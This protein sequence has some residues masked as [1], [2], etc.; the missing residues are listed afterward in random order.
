MSGGVDSSIAAHLLKNAGYSLVGLTM[1]IWDNRIPLPD[2]GFSG[3]FGPGEARDIAAAQ[4]LAKRLDIPHH[5]VPLANEYAD[6]ILS[7]FRQE[8]TAGRTP[9]P[10]VRCN[11][12]MKF[13]LLLQR[14]RSMGITF[15]HF[16]TGHYARVEHDP[17]SGRHLLYRAVDHRKDQSYFL[18]RLDQPKLANVMFPLGN[19]TKDAV[20]LLARDIGWSDVADKDE[21]QNFIESDNYGVLFNK[22]E[23][24]PGPIVDMSGNILGQHKGIIHYTIGQRRG[25]GLSG[26]KDPLFVVRLEACANTVVVGS[27]HELFATR[28]QATHVNWISC[29]APPTTPVRVQAKIRQQHQEAPA[30]LTAISD[31]RGSCIQLDFD[32]AQMAI[33]PGQTVVCYEGDRVLCGATIERACGNH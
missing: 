20:K 6:E 28:L 2:K 33:T 13:G 12:D 29:A 14:A 24:S 15:D 11:R 1:Q 9:N 30:L 25:L 18:S 3:C 21:S 19:L 10:C 17:S 7:Y 22:E 8:Y 23:S 26:T 32:E 5:I 31:S 27:H 4:A 16:A